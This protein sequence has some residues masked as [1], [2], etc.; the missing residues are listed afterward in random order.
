MLFLY[1]I[2][3]NLEFN[4]FTDSPIIVSTSNNLP[5]IILFII[6]WQDRNW[7]IVVWCCLDPV[8][9]WGKGHCLWTGFDLLQSRPFFGQQHSVSM[10]PSVL[11][12]RFLFQPFYCYKVNFYQNEVLKILL[13]IFLYII[14]LLTHC[15]QL[16]YKLFTHRAIKRNFLGNEMITHTQMKHI[17]Q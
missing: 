12:F 5:R 8:V 11:F 4:P 9:F 7:T 17:P 16:I 3:T 10:R 13:F 15:K 6:S 2:M 1:N 14:L